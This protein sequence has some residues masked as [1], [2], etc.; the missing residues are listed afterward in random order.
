MNVTDSRNSLLIFTIL[1]SFKSFFTFKLV[2]TLHVR[3]CVSVI[4]GAKFQNCLK[5]MIHEFGGIKVAMQGRI[6]AYRDTLIKCIFHSAVVLFTMLQVNTCE[7]AL[8]NAGFICTN[9]YTYIYGMNYLLHLA[10]LC[11]NVD[12]SCIIYSE[13]S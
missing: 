6:K 8:G 13:N 2:R 11:G 9:V 7:Y 5:F 3:V 4:L 10:T 12:I 1:I